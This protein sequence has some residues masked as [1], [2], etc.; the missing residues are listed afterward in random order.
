M[1]CYGVS[2]VDCK[3]CAHKPTVQRALHIYYRCTRSAEAALQTLLSGNLQV[4]LPRLSFYST[5]NMY[6]GVQ[7][8][9]QAEKTRQFTTP[10]ISSS[11]RMS[12][13]S[14][15]FN[16]CWQVAAVGSAA[17]RQIKTPHLSRRGHSRCHRA[18]RYS[19]ALDT[20]RGIEF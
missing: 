9:D 16:T 18:S 12:V 15:L 1:P 20:S 11:T 4:D 3:V 10:C 14:T 2:A 8:L 7:C 13:W 6:T 17:R 19:R 5:S